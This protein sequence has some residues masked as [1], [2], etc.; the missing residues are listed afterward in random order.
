MKVD[1]NPFEVSLSF[2][3]PIF[4]STNV[5][6]IEADYVSNVGRMRWVDEL[7]LD[8]FKGVEKLIFPIAGE[9]LLDFLSR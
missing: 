9:S 2:G 4:I 5:A 8:H 1:T 3:G 6:G 7:E